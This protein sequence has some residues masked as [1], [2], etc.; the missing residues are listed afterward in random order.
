MVTKTTCRK[1]VYF[2]FKFEMD[3][4]Q[5]LAGMT[6]GTGHC[7]IASYRDVYKNWSKALTSQ[8]PGTYFL[9]QRLTS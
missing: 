4:W 6:A 2:D 8:S 5:Q 7:K 3:E 9:Q 1:K